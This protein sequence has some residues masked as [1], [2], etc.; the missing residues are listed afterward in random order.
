MPQ[1][2]L[3]PADGGPGS[4]DLEQGENGPIEP[5]NRFQAGHSEQFWILDFA[6]GI[7]KK[8]GPGKKGSEIR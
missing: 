6:L 3:G 4:W 2:R 7:P 1:A 5:L 8:N